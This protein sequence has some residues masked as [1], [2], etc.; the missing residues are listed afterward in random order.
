MRRSQEICLPFSCRHLASL[1]AAEGAAFWKVYGCKT[2]EVCLFEQ[3]KGVIFVH[4]EHSAGYYS[5]FFQIC[6]PLNFPD[7]FFS[8]VF[9]PDCGFQPVP[10]GFSFPVFRCAGMSNFAR[11]EKAVFRSFERLKSPRSV[12]KKYCPPGRQFIPFPPIFSKKLLRGAQGS[13]LDPAF[14]PILWNLT[15][16]ADKL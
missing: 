11:F 14:R 9:A 13:R 15:K 10:H 8:A 1:I 3:L 5:K 6:Q 16:I 2:N 4:I 12:P 7:P